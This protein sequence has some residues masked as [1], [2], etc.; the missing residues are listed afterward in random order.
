MNSLITTQLP[1]VLTGIKLGIDG[2]SS[3][4]LLFTFFIWFISGVYA[5]YYMKGQKNIGRFFLFYIISAAGNIGLILAQDM[6]SFYLF[7]ALM[8]FAA[9]PLIVHDK[10]A[11]ARY[12][13][14][15][16][17]IMAVIGEAMLISAIM[18]I[19]AEDETTAFNDIAAAI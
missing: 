17:I 18:M 7:F 11:G 13:G 5:S 6:V 16:Y 15:V 3:V 4:F 8:T 10:T 12:A 19:A 2:I 14:K 1:S 9:Y